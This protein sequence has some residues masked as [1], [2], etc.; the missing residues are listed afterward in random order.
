LGRIV[1]QN[2]KQVREYQRKHSARLAEEQLANSGDMDSGVDDWN[3]SNM[4]LDTIQEEEG[5]LRRPK[6]ELLG[7]G[8]SDFNEDEDADPL[9]K[10]ALR[11]AAVE[12]VL[13]GVV[14]YAVNSRLEDGKVDKNPAVWKPELKSKKPERRSSSKK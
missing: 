14:S 9:L 10:E 7:T 4:F 5:S 1:Q 6:D 11:N 8:G 13:E 12:A 3:D 2:K